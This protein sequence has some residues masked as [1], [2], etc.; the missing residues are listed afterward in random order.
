LI[1]SLKIVSCDFYFPSKLFDYFKFEDSN[2]VIQEFKYTG[3]V[4]NFTVPNDT[5]IVTIHAFGAQGGSIYGKQNKLIVDGGAGGC[6]Q[7]SINVKP[8]D[9][10]FIYIGGRGSNSTSTWFGGF[11][12]GGNGTLSY[13]GGGGG[14]TDIR[15]KENDLNSR[16][17]VA[18]GGGGWGYC[19]YS[20]YKT[21][22]YLSGGSGGGKFGKKGHGPDN[23]YI[24]GLFSCCYESGFGGNQ[25]HGGYGGGKLGVGGSGDSGGGGGYYGGGCGYGSA[26]GGGSNFA[27]NK[28]DAKFNNNNNVDNL[29]YQDCNRGDGY[30]TI[31]YNI[32][33]TT[34]TV[35]EEIK[36]NKQNISSATI[37]KTKNKSAIKYSWFTFFLCFLSCGLSLAAIHMFSTFLIKILSNNNNINNNND[38][39]RHVNLNR[40]EAIANLKKNNNFLNN[41]KEIKQS[42]TT[43]TNSNDELL[44][45]FYCVICFEN[46]RDVVFL[47]CKHSC[48]CSKCDTIL[49]EANNNNCPICQQIITRRIIMYQ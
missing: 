47:E 30:L 29:G 36:K 42:N 39:N 18:G 24:C 43:T 20:F 5:F 41:K 34:S 31:M 48:V 15:T 33:K 44:L 1:F 7:T 22:H 19:S 2:V 23:K 46:F 35:N 14:A 17:V 32:T 3:K 10:L 9:K 12:G 11:N 49:I 8:K 16:L 27:M 40:Y 4:Q 26:G 37:T 25:T 6:I 45:N 13:G 21:Q 28:V 38:N